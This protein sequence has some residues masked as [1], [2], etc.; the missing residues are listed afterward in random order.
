MKNNIF[1]EGLP[2]Y[3]KSTLLNR[4]AR[5]WPEYQVYRQG[6]LSPAELAWCS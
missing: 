6:D 5:T 4:L 1:I 2:G 3:G